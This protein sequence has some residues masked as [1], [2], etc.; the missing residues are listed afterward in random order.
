MSVVANLQRSNL[1]NIERALAFEKILNAGIFKNK[2]E[3]S[4]AIGKDETYIGDLMNMLK[5]DE[6]ILNHV[7]K[8]NPN[9]DV[10]ALRIIRKA[11]KLDK[12]GKSDKQH[13]LYLN[14]VHKKLSR[15][16]LQKK[17]VRQSEAE[18]Q[19]S[20]PKQFEIQTIK[21]GYK[22]KIGHEL[23]K[24]QQEKLKGLLEEKLTRLFAGI[25]AKAMA[26]LFDKVVKQQ[27]KEK[28]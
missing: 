22:L 10:R 16:Q 4:R 6:R 15:E 1:S 5:M 14:Y 26:R 28:E 8:S 2:K 27:L 13:K 19:D 17:V 24:N 18:K 12:S 21:D 23:N 9:A 20:H 3:L 11:G 7:A 25:I